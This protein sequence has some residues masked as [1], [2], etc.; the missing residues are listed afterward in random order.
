MK[1]WDYKNL[2]RL[3]IS[4][5]LIFGLMMRSSVPALETIILYQSTYGV[6][7]HGPV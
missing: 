5:T 7:V 6:I 1:G 2:E 4:S 3:T